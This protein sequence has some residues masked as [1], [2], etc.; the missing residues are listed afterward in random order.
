MAETNTVAYNDMVNIKTVKGFARHERKM[1]T[2][3]VT[4]LLLQIMLI[5]GAD[6]C[7]NGFSRED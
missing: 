1:K 7:C 3:S 5:F 2:N 6:D 4:T